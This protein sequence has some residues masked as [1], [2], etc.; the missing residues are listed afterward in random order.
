MARS[1]KTPRVDKNPDA[2]LKKDPYLQSL[3]EMYGSRMT[4]F[5]DIS[6]HEVNAIADYITGHYKGY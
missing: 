2:F 1:E 5:P 6:L 3:R 4:A